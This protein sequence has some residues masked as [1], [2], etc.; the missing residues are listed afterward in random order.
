MAT[1]RCGLTGCVGCWCLARGDV[2]VTV[3]CCGQWLLNDMGSGC[4]ALWEVL[5]AVA[6]GVSVLWEND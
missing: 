1:G 6:T 4:Q 2:V 3:G 5:W